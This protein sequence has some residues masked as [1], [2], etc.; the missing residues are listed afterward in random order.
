MNALI[1]EQM[2][3][4]QTSCLPEKLGEERFHAL[5]GLLRK[6]AVDARRKLHRRIRHVT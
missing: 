3:Y 6:S 1:G 5:R 2:A 4:L